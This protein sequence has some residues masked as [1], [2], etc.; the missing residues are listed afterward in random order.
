MSHRFDKRFR[1]LDA[2]LGDKRSSRAVLP[3]QKELPDGVDKVEGSLGATAFTRF[4]NRL[5]GKDPS[6]RHA[7]GCG[8]ALR[9]TGRAGGVKYIG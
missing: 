1:I 9:P 7:M 3:G 6:H 8:D 5:L 4:K 2:R